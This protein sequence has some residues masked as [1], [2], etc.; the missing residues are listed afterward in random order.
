MV[1]SKVPDNGWNI[2]GALM[3]GNNNQRPLIGHFKGIGKLK[4]GTQNTQ[5]PQQKKI[6]PI[7]GFFVSSITHQPM[8]KD[9]DQ[10]EK[11]QSRNE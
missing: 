6:E 2:I 5:T 9:L 10:V 1:F 7:N 11:N 8:A 4:T 3:I